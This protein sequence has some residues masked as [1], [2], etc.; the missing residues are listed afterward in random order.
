MRLSPL[1]L[2]AAGVAA[3]MVAAA[4]AQTYSTPSGQGVETG[5]PRAVRDEAVPTEK[6]R[7]AED[8]RLQAELRKI[9]AGKTGVTKIEPLRLGARELVSVTAQRDEQTVVLLVPQVRRTG[10]RAWENPE[11]LLTA[12]RALRPEQYEV[13]HTEEA[14]GVEWITGVGEGSPTTLADMARRA[15]GRDAVTDGPRKPTGDE[16]KATDTPAP[17]EAAAS[18]VF[19][20]LMDGQIDGKPY[21]AVV[22][23]RGVMLTRTELWLAQVRSR[24]GLAAPRA[25]VLAEAAKLTPGDRI[26]VRYVTVDGRLYVTELKKD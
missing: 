2:T 19:V 16:T 11:E 24:G 25:D 3:T 5:R 12:L 17:A 23:Q 6:E 8:R 20:E 4:L 7:L 18:G 1:M 10:R 13:I 21:K 9:R 26:T 22:M 14:Y 15:L